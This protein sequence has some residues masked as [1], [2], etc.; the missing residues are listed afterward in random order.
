MKKMLLLLTLG[1]V[2]VSLFTPAALATS[3]YCGYDGYYDDDYYYGYDYCGD[4]Y[5]PSYFAGSA[6]ASP[7]ATATA[8]PTA[9][10]TAS[11]TATASATAL[12]ATGGASV[13]PA[14]TLMASLALI[15]SGLGAL[16]LVRRGAS[17]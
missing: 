6:T 17:S 4:S 14:L 8:S 9:T 16:M 2:M 7:T 3:H 5:Y 10:A 15:G 12:A 13:V 11:P 1:G